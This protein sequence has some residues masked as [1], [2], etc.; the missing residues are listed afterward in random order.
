MIRFDASLL[1]ANYPE[2]EF[3]IGRDDN[4]NPFLAYAFFTGD[5]QDL[6]WSFENITW[7]EEDTKFTC[8]IFN[9][10]DGMDDDETLR[11]LQLEYFEKF[12]QTVIVPDKT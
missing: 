2:L 4:N 12:L 11:T 8:E 7:N 6:V 9:Y 1:E 10:V 3:R 5:Y